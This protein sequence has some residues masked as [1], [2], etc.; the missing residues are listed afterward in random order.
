ML[1]WT[2]SLAIT[3]CCTVSD[4]DVAIII[5]VVCVCGWGWGGGLYV[6]LCVRQAENVCF[7][8]RHLHF[9]GSVA[10]LE[11]HLKKK[12]KKKEI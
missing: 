3:S 9:E 1:T 2:M 6:S 5:E 4:V 10:E 12:K 7:V 8:C 11:W